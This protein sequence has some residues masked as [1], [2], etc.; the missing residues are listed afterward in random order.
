MEV[1]DLLQQAAEAP[2]VNSA[3][4]AAAAAAA[5][6]LGGGSYLAGAMEEL[7]A[8]LAL[9][10]AR[11]AEDIVATVC[12]QFVQPELSRRHVRAFCRG[13]LLPVICRL[14]RPASRGLLAA[15]T[16]ATK[17][18]PASV[19]AAL[20]VPLLRLPQDR[21][22][23]AQ[24]EVVQRVV[25]QCLAPRNAADLL[26]LALDEDQGWI[27]GH[28]EDQASRSGEH[29]ASGSGVGAAATLALT[30]V[31][32]PVVS[33]IVSVPRIEL[34]GACLA[35]LCD[36]I[37][38]APAQSPA[39]NKSLKFSSLVLTIARKHGSGL[40]PHVASL[41][42]VASQIQTFMAKPIGAALAKLRR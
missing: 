27:Q 9:A 2:L 29:A 25:K 12:A 41:S 23:S 8:F 15:V 30:E 31:S 10:R 7:C 33:A 18:D 26:A 16:A 11:G 13:V 36:R 3:A 42:R 19:T 5:A 21:L 20:L 32:I 35:G 39:L 22:G 17:V 37:A 40:A 28:H 24:C 4:A 38:L 34:S 1:L 14:R 6:T